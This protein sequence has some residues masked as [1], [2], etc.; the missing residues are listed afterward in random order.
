MHNT[1]HKHKNAKAFSPFNQKSIK[2][3][4]L[5]QLQ[6]LITALSPE[7]EKKHTLTQY[8]LNKLSNNMR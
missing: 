2:A 3:I 1:K 8:F 7:A 5:V 6:L 4:S